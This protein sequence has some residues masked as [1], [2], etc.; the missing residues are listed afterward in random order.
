MTTKTAKRKTQKT[1]KVSKTEFLRA[2]DV[3]VPSQRRLAMSVVQDYF[4]QLGDEY[5]NR[6]AEIGKYDKELVKLREEIAEKICGEVGLIYRMV[7]WSNEKDYYFSAVTP[8]LNETDV[9][10]LLRG[11]RKAQ[12]AWRQIIKQSK[13]EASQF[14]SEVPI[15][16]ASG[17][18]D[19][20]LVAL[21][22]LGA[23]VCPGFVLTQISQVCPP[24]GAPGHG[25]R[26]FRLIC[27]MPFSAVKNRKLSSLIRKREQAEAERKKSSEAI[28]FTEGAVFG[29][30]APFQSHTFPF[31]LLSS[32][33][34]RSYV[35]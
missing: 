19:G 33:W 22:T 32:L 6:C 31:S 25:K 15:I 9:R 12:A 17:L 29:K 4:L 21:A 26:S 11:N 8:L 3:L 24:V 35:D 28:R 10:E 7:S 13:A 5:R 30:L 23:V 1:K 20:G 18:K 2:I 16:R 34:G 27:D 14:G